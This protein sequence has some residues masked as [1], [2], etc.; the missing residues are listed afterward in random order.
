MK[1]TV[2]EMMFIIDV[3]THEGTAV[4]KIANDVGE[5]ITRL[6]GELIKIRRMGLRKLAYPIQKKSEGYYYLAYFTIESSGLVE[7]DRILRLNDSILRFLVTVALPTVVADLAQISDDIED[8][9]TEA[10]EDIE[11]IEEDD[12]DFDDD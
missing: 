7:L 6:G 9:E 5:T 3:T 8:D 12:D 2:Y 11:V 1:Q 4:Q 10:S